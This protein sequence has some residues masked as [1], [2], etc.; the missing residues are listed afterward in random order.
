LPLNNK[1][2]SLKNLRRYKEALEC[3]NKAIEVDPKEPVSYYNKG[4]TY[5]LMEN[6]D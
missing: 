5:K 3:F 2:A 1:R 4:N 6:Y